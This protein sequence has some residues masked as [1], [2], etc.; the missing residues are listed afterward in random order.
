[1]RRVIQ[2]VD[3]NP[4]LFPTVSPPMNA[5]G[6]THVLI[7]TGL[8][9]SDDHAISAAEHGSGG[10]GNSDLF[11]SALGFIKSQS[12]RRSLTSRLSDLSHLC[13]NHESLSYRAK[14]RQSRQSTSNAFNRRTKTRTRRRAPASPW[15]RLPWELPPLCRLSKNSRAAERLPLPTRDTVLVVVAAEGVTCRAS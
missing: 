8:T 14:A 5:Q 15:T 10:S 4:L 3:T 13:M 6:S 2:T 7:P 1:M 12:V 9:V 11:K